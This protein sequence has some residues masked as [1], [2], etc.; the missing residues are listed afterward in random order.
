DGRSRA[1]Q[2]WTPEKYLQVLDDRWRRAVEGQRKGRSASAGRA[3]P[4]V[5]TTA[6]ITPQPGLPRRL[7]ASAAGLTL[8]TSP[9]T[10]TV[11]T[12]SAHELGATKDDLALNHPQ[13]DRSPPHSASFT[14]SP[15]APA[16]ATL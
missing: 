3:R 14:W 12:N 8:S 7:S 6:A 2:A 11:T 15:S 13:S 1:A 10:T 16:R 4:S 5:P 9:T